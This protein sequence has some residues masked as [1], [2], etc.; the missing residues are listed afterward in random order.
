MLFPVRDLLDCGTGDDA[1]ENRLRREARFLADELNAG[2]PAYEVR[3]IH[4]DTDDYL[5]FIP[6][7]DEE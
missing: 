5:E 7:P 6:S 2:L 1:L 4:L 3:L